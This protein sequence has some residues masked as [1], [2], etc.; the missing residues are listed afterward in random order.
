MEA[1]LI[2]TLTLKTK[3]KY[4]KENDSLNGQPRCVEYSRIRHLC[5]F[6]MET[7]SVYSDK[8]NVIFLSGVSSDKSFKE[9]ALPLKT[10]TCLAITYKC[11]DLMIDIT[12]HAFDILK[13]LPHLLLGLLS[14][15]Y[16]LESL[17]MAVRKMISIILNMSISEIMDLDHKTICKLTRDITRVS[18]FDG[19]IW[20]K[21]CVLCKTQILIHAGVRYTHPTISMLPCCCNLI[22]NRCISR[23][24]PSTKQNS[25]QCP[26]CDSNY[27][28]G[29]HDPSEDH[30]GV[31]IDRHLSIDNNCIPRVIRIDFYHPSLTLILNRFNR[32]VEDI[33]NCIVSIPWAVIT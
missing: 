23:A 21:H 32:F 33:P 20:T 10:L 6:S 5:K 25:S 18:I 19:R 15:D 28:E 14:S 16:K 11:T 30:L 27:Y 8:N 3:C 4:F 17:I 1:R 22:H 2:N 9:M 26:S 12:E 29:V 31:T 13:P 24:F 7:D